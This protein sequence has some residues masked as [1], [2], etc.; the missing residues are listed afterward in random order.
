VNKSPD[1]E[2]KFKRLNEAYEVLKDPDKRRHYD[3]LDD[4]WQAW[5]DFTPPLGWEFF[6]ARPGA[7][8]VFGFNFFDDDFEESPFSGFSD[9]FSMLFGGGGFNGGSRSGARA[10]GGGARA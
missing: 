1:A 10:G 9:F 6:G 5:Q 3:S 8:R 4:N 7:Q 2:E